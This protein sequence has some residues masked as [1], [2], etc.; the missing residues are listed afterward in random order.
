MDSIFC[1]YPVLAV[2]WISLRDPFTPRCAVPLTSQVGPVGIEGPG[3]DC[4]FPVRLHGHQRY[5]ILDTV[6]RVDR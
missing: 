4:G 6:G 3:I 5:W 1:Y 2:Y